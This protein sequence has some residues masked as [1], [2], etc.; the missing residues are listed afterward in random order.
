RRLRPGRRGV[1]G[2]V[3]EAGRRAVPG[4]GAPAPLPGRRRAGHDRVRRP[5]AAGR[6]RPGRRPARRRRGGRLLL[7]PGIPGPPSP[8]RSSVAMTATELYQMPEDGHAH[9]RRLMGWW[10]MLADLCIADLLLFVPVIGSK[11]SRFMILGQ[12][13]PTTG[14]TLHRE[15]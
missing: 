13:R 1:V 7:A 4:A 5:L 2:R 14:Q 11:G 8:F 10:G 12:I 9:L 15:D 3:A 6:R